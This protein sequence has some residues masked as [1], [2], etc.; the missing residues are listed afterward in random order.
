MIYYIVKK[1]I[2]L[3]V[4]LNLFCLP[5]F[6]QGISK[7]KKIDQS[8]EARVRFTTMPLFA[9]TLIDKTST[10]DLLHF[11]SDFRVS[12]SL[13]LGI[14]NAYHFDLSSLSPAGRIGYAFG[15][16]R[17]FSTTW[18]IEGN[19]EPAGAMPMI[20]RQWGY[21][22]GFQMSLSLAYLIHF[23]RKNT[24]FPFPWFKIGWA[25]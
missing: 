16:H 13:F 8:K 12:R 9:L 21:D 7:T 24:P 17:A 5:L 2:L 1:F 20:T 3:S 25:F 18:M 10:N 22:S 14:A 11:T 4:L 19:I 6:S 15:K 23:D